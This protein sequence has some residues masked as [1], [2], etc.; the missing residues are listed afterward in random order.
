[1]FK[2]MDDIKYNFVTGGLPYTKSC[3]RWPNLKKITKLW[4]ANH[5]Q[6]DTLTLVH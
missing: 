4:K 6:I 2:I 3:E 1:M 5:A